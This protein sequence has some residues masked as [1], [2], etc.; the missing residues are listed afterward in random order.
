[1]CRTGSFG[2][3]PFED[4]ILNENKGPC[5]VRWNRTGLYETKPLLLSVLRAWGVCSL[6]P[7][8]D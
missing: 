7:F 6:L 8:T 5:P 1:M 2:I 4:S 3:V